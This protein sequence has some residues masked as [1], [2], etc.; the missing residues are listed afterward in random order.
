MRGGW[1]VVGCEQGPGTR[2][3]GPGMNTRIR[4][5]RDLTVWQRAMDL[6]TECYSAT[7]HFP[8]CETYGMTI[9]IRRAAVSIPS[10]IAEGNGRTML[11]DYLR[12]LSIANGSLMELETQVQ[13]ARRFGY[14]SELQEIQLLS[15][16]REVGRM[17]ARLMVTLRDRRRSP[18]PRSLVPGPSAP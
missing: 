2:D 3:Q 4:D 16:G 15:I 5:Y 11:G 12:H 9:Q 18:D 17:L 7:K 6:G 1:R 14:L 8:K 13:L 10:N